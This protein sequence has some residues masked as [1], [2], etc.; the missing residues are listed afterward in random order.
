[1]SND[2]VQL[3][4]DRLDY[5]M[6]ARREYPA[7]GCIGGGDYEYERHTDY[8]DL[9]RVLCVERCYFDRLGTDAGW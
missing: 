2:I 6:A 7:L 8:G 3:P 1:M 4:G 9:R 5:G